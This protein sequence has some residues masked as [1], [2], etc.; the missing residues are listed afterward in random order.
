M[1][2]NLRSRQLNPCDHLFWKCRGYPERPNN[3][4]EILENMGYYDRDDQNDENDSQESFESETD[5][6]EDE[7]CEEECDDEYCEEESEDE[8]SEE[9][10]EDEESEMEYEDEESEMEDEGSEEEY[11]D[12]ESEEEYEAHRLNSNQNNPNNDEYW[13]LRGWS[14]RPD[15]W[16]E[17]IYGN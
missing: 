1:N 2:H 7:S 9:E 14:Q 17:R 10:Y 13:R 16:R 11:Q 5:S 8:C 3:W 12:E 15:D 4:E 6:Y